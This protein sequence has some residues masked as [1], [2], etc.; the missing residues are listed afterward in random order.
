MAVPVKFEAVRRLDPANPLASLSLPAWL[1][2]SLSGLTA[3]SIEVTRA[4]GVKARM[5]VPAV[6]RSLSPSISM[7]AA[8][9]KRTGELAAALVAFD[10]DT[11]AA[12]VSD[13]LLG[14]IVQGL[15][16]SGHEGRARS[17]MMALDDLPAWAV[18][19]ACRRWLRHEAGEHNYAFPPTPPILRDLAVTAKVRVEGQLRSLNK[20]LEAHVV[21]DPPVYSEEHRAEMQEKLQALFVSVAKK[22]TP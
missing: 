22:T 15:G 16:D 1:N 19:D 20:L 21:D 9:E 11:L 8:I 14:F 17:Y 4:D 6:Q 12:N 7:Q 18:G 13:M 10:T 3:N 5:V 2:A